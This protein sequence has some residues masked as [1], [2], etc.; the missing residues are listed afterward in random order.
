MERIAPQDRTEAWAKMRDG[1]RIKLD[2]RVPLQSCAF[3]A[4]RSDYVAIEALVERM[5]TGAVAIDV[6]A[7][8][9]LFTVPLALRAA[10][11][12]GH[13]YAFEPM[14]GSYM[15]LLENITA[16]DLSAITTCL[17]LALGAENGQAEIE[18]IEVRT[19]NAMR[20]LEPSEISQRVTIKRLDDL[21]QEVHIVRCDVI[22]VDIEGGELD[23]LRGAAR[24]IRQQRPTIYLELNT[25]HMQRLGW[26]EDDVLTLAADWGYHALLQTT[27]GF[28]PYTERSGLMDN[29]LLIPGRDSRGRDERLSAIGPREVTHLHWVDKQLGVCGSS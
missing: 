14:P 8:V 9:G 19:G 10:E 29:V 7:N 5:P 23:F 28:V 1:S 2:L 21:A 25:P 16:N 18:P 26:S 22:K 15:R 12:G 3:W 24:F 20:V 13:V 17:Q 27:S 4:G 11:T 6:G